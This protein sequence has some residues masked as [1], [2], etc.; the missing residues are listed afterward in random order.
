[1]GQRGTELQAPRQISAIVARC[2]DRLR[3]HV[4]NLLGA[5]ELLALFKEAML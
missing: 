5:P 1:M 3:L 4:A 2:I